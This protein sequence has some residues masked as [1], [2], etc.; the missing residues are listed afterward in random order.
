MPPVAE[1]TA[2]AARILT[3]YN[4]L[5]YTLLCAH[6]ATTGYFIYDLFYSLAVSNRLITYTVRRRTSLFGCILVLIHFSA[7]GV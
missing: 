4:E 7:P 6:L 1:L 3:F 2:H 5:K